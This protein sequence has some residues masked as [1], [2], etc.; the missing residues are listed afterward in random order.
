MS[1]LRSSLERLVACHAPRGRRF[2]DQRVCSARGSRPRS[3]RSIAFTSGVGRRAERQTSRNSLSSSDLVGGASIRISSREPAGASP[4]PRPLQGFFDRRSRPATLRTS[5][6]WTARASRVA[7][8][9]ADRSTRVRGTEVTGIPL[10]VV[11]VLR[12]R[13]RACVWRRD[14]GP[15]RR[16]RAGRSGHRPCGGAVARTARR[17]CGPVTHRGA[18]ADPEKGGE[19]EPSG[20]ARCGRRRTRRGRGVE[21]PAA[22]LRPTASGRGRRRGAGPP[23]RRRPGRR[24]LGDRRVG[25][26]GEF[27]RYSGQAVIHREG[28]GGKT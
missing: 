16:P 2:G 26:C 4:P 18:L 17:R 14:S 3:R 22:T 27:V 6:S 7:S 1:R 20:R 5:A 8:S 24:D 28:E 11:D 9:T 25:R 10:I 15:L 12:R 19:E 23:T 21:P 13:G